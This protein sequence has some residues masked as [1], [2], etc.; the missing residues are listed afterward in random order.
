MS[1]ITGKGIITQRCPLLVEAIYT[2][3]RVYEIYPWK[4]I[5]AKND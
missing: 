1:S 2:M 4:K 5:D 3:Y